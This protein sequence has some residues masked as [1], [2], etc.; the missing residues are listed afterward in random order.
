MQK[1][2]AILCNY[3]LVKLKIHAKIGKD[4]R[5]PPSKMTFME[6]NLNS[7]K[8]PKYIC[9]NC[10]A[11]L[12]KDKSGIQRS[13]LPQHQQPVFNNVILHPPALVLTD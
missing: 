3:I 8:S 1:L 7:C 9:R 13:K 2:L 5:Q 6:G 12:V 11:P 10:M 4:G